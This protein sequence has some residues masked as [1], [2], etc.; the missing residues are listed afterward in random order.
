[1]SLNP[2]RAAFERGRRA[3]RAEAVA[4]LREQAALHTDQVGDARRR[5][6][7][8][9]AADAIRDDRKAGRP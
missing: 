9:A 3:G 6:A 5:G 2:I 1:M 8:N 7:L 4:F